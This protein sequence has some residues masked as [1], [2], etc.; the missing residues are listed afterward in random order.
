[1]FGAFKIY[2]KGVKL[3]KTKKD[4]IEHRVTKSEK[5]IFAPNYSSKEYEISCRVVA[6][7]KTIDKVIDLS[8][9]LMSYGSY[10][11]IDRL[12]ILEKIDWNGN[13]IDSWNIYE[14]ISNQ[15]YWINLSRY[16]SFIE[17]YNNPGEKKSGERL[18]EIRYI[19]SEDKVSTCDSY[20]SDNNLLDFNTLSAL[21]DKLLQLC[22]AL[23]LCDSIETEEIVDYLP[24]RASEHVYGQSSTIAYNGA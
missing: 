4:H 6:Y 19:C 14:E 11:K 5:Y 3:V 21:V 9:R 22:I 10:Q 1:M 23:G 17:G 8:E 20:S 7:N 13:V 15:T 18:I 16:G 24:P 2:K 12:K